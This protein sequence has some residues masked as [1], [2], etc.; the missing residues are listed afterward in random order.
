[1]LLGDGVAQ[2]PKRGAALVMEAADEGDPE[3]LSLLATLTAAGVWGVGQSW[4]R[5]LDLLARAAALGSVDAAAQLG[6][7]G[8]SPE[9]FVAFEPPVKVCESPQVWTAERFV[10]PALCAWL[11]AQGAGKFK[12]ALMREAST[13]NSA[14]LASRTCSDFVFDILAGGVAM[15]LLR[16]KIAR[17]TGIPP[18]HMEPPQ[19]FHYAVGEE[20]KP[21]YDFLFDGRNAY[22]R[23]GTY[24][25]DRL[26]TFLLYLNEGYGGGELEFVKAGY[27]YKGRAGDGIF[28][29]SQK[30]GKQDWQSLH[31][32]APVTSGEKFILSQWIHDRPFAA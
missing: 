18:P 17:A 19:I 27:R 7:I 31:A 3:A 5:A 30:D 20:I 16:I 2:E 10:D 15:L 24:R 11:V 32:A 14:A 23:D 13:G 8:E 28:F 29:A 21:H 22:G 4:P 6:F 25:G 1:M 9:R 12:P 26:V